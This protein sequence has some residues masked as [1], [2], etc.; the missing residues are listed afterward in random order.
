MFVHPSIS[1]FDIIFP[2]TLLQPSFPKSNP[3]FYPL[4]AYFLV[5]YVCTKVGYCNVSFSRPLV[6]LFIFPLGRP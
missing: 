1:P 2:C 4:L 3:P 5:R 6:L